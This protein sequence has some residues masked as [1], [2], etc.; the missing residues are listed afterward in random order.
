MGL[1]AYA[2]LPYLV[3]LHHEMRNQTNK[4]RM[5]FHPHVGISCDF[6]SLHHRFTEHRMES[7][8]N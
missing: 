6:L 1:K 2:P 5:K 4:N 3:S 7:E 8:Q